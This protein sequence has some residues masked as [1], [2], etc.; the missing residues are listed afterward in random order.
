MSKVPVVALLA[1][2]PR[3]DSLRSLALPSIA[4]Q[5]KP[6]EHVVLVTDRQALSKRCTTELADTLAGLPLTVLNNTRPAGAAGSWNTGI[7]W[8][9]RHYSDP[10][11]AILDDDDTWEEDH[12]ALCDHHSAQGR[13]H[14]VL[15]GIRILRQA[16]LVAALTPTHVCVDDFLRGNPGWQGSNTY[17]RLTTLRQAGGFRD[18]LVSSNDRDL[19][20]RVLDL[21]D[22]HLA[23]TGQPSVTWHCGG[24]A[25]ALSTP[26]SQQKRLGSAQFYRAHRS[27][28]SEKTESAFFGRLQQLFGVAKAD[29]LRTLAELPD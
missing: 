5:S 7:D 24:Q 14:V 8:I 21:P 3:L 1:S 6:P 26:G 25:D 13:A 17:I 15:S 2:I 29:I 23:Y 19:A 9:A 11:V 28:M 27:R 16:R 20:I 10:Y 18:G 22:V 12:L 4:R